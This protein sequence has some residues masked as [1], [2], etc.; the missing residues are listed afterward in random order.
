MK[1]TD[2]CCDQDGKCGACVLKELAPP[3]PRV[4]KKPNKAG[5]CDCLTH[6]PSAGFRYTAHELHNG[7]VIDVQ[8]IKCDNCKMTL[9]DLKKVKPDKL[10]KIKIK[11]TTPIDNLV[12]VEWCKK[13]CTPRK[14]CN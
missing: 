13:Q 8:Y 4:I 11:E 2:C 5:I 10:E 3:P 12:W 14:K 1:L 9:V 7:K 6:D